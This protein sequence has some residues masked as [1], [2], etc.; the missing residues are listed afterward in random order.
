MA[1]SWVHAAQRFDFRLNHRGCRQDASAPDQEALA[2]ARRASGPGARSPTIRLEAVA[3]A[4]RAVVTDVWVSMGDRRC[5]SKAVSRLLAPYRVDDRADG[6]RGQPDT[7]F[8][9]CLPAHRGEEVV[10]AVIDGPQSVVF[11][12]AEN[13]LHA[14]KGILAWCLG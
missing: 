2:W 6:G 1:T 7:V 4:S 14:Q 11:D 13:R 9:H 12:Q 3:G 10:A 5:R 8:M